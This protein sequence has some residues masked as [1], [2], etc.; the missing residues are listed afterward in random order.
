MKKIKENIIKKFA[1]N[2]FLVDALKQFFSWNLLLNNKLYQKFTLKKAKNFAKHNSYKIRGVSIETT[3]SC[4]AKCVMCYHSKKNMIGTMSM[5]LFKKIINDCVRNNIKTISLS[6]Y[7]EPLLD[8]Y[9]FERIMYLRKY[10]LNYSFFTNGSLLNKK[11]ARR[12]FELG[13][14]KKI[15]FSVSGY[16]SEIYETVMK[17]LIRD[18]VYKN[19]LNFLKLKKEYGRDDLIAGISF[20]KTKHNKKEKAQFLKYWKKQKGL[21]HLITADLWDRIG[22]YDATKVGKLGKLHIKKKWLP[23]CSELWGDIYVYFD[24]RVGPCCS[25]GDLRRIIIGD[26]NKQTIDEIYK[27]EKLNFLRKL[28]LNNQRNRHPVCFKCYRNTPWLL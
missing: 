3:L 25:D 10:N 23:P 6:V 4:N 2:P 22:E 5:K 24:G 7:G 28:H 26:L 11:N 19:I 21:N 20:V 9:L 17:G 13:G 12:F 8:K 1:K 16:S 27:A 14:L 18:T 15:N